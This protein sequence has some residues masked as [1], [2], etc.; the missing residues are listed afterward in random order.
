MLQFFFEPRF[1]IFF[2]AGA[3]TLVSVAES[4]KISSAREMYTLAVMMLSYAL[5]A[6]AIK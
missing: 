2:V 1:S 5:L 4:G 6:E 3:M